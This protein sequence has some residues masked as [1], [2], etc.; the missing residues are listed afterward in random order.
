MHC[1]V[2]ESACKLYNNTH[3]G[4]YKMRKCSRIKGERKCESDFCILYINTLFTHSH[5]E[6]R[7]RRVE[8]PV[9]GNASGD[10]WGLYSANLFS[11]ASCFN[12]SL[13]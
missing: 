12:G 10:R 2:K 1:C 6:V 7:G 3:T 9:S 13:I 5:A 4:D 8:A 11:I